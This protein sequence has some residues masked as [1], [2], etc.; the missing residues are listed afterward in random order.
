MHKG[1]YEA[2]EA[3]TG[4]EDAIGLL[5]DSSSSCSVGCSDLVMSSNVGC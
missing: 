1:A 5:V 2:P 4:V 3:L